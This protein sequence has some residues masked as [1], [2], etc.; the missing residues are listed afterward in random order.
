MGMIA[1]RPI[2]DDEMDFGP[3]ADE[4]AVLDAKMAKLAEEHRVAKGL[5]AFREAS[6]KPDS[7]VWAE[8][9][10]DG[11]ELDVQRVSDIESKE[12]RWLWKKRVPLGKGTLLAGYPGVSKS[13]ATLDWAAR[14][15][16]GLDWPLGEPNEAGDVI[17][18]SAEDDA[19]DTIKPRLVAAGADT[20]R[21]HVIFAV[22]HRGKER[23]FTLKDD[24]AKLERLLKRLPETR[25]VIIDPI[26]AYLGD[27]NSWKDSE[28]RA[29]LAP[30]SKLAAEHDVAIVM[31][32]HL[33]KKDTDS[34]N[35]VSGSGAFVAAP[36]AAYLFARDD[37][38]LC[39]MASLKLNITKR[40]TT[41]SY[42]IVEK[43][44]TAVLAWD[45]TP[46]KETAESLLDTHSRTRVADAKKFLKRVLTPPE[47]GPHAA[48]ELFHW[49]KM[50][51]FAKRTLERAK[52]DLK[53]Q[54]KQDRGPD[55]QLK[56][57]LWSLP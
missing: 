15:S 52:S 47:G 51:G 46:S 1:Q 21:C 4:Q 7:I 12:V 38:D 43:D 3:T 27:V 19:S 39:H 42:R 34:I 31:V 35:R 33:N 45:K 28:V 54:S 41:L 2:P 37:T 32:T 57:G 56:E 48:S 17:I 24:L 50:V 53:I 10:P 44:G 23:L 29:V 13:L 14:V 5:T 6:K 55:G 18:L 36:R 25:L 20:D 16:A 40:P 30:L 22:K 49:A 9:K 11:G 26:S 8:A